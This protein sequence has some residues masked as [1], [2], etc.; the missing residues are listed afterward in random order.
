MWTCSREGEWVC[1]FVTALQTDCQPSVVLLLHCPVYQAHQGFLGKFHGPRF[2]TFWIT[3]HLVLYCCY[4]LKLQRLKRSSSLSPQSLFCKWKEVWWWHFDVNIDVTRPV[5]MDMIKIWWQ[6]QVS[7]GGPLFLSRTIMM[8]PG[9]L[10]KSFS[11]QRGWIETCWSVIIT[12]LYPPRRFLSLHVNILIV[13]FFHLI[14]VLKWCPAFQTRYWS[15][16]QMPVYIDLCV[17]KSS[18]STF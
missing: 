5:L 13:T 14:I 17:E 3:L 10:F 11:R 9:G 4:C 6:C 18:S 1:L 16:I 12:S 8:I 7:C 2:S 15:F